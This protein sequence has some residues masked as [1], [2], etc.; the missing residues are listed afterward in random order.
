MHRKFSIRI[1][2]SCSLVSNHS[3]SHQQLT[4]SPEY[5]LRRAEIPIKTFSIHHFY[6]RCACNSSPIRV[7]YVTVLGRLVTV[8]GRLVTVAIHITDH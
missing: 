4:L 7:A 2:T 5:D 6:I 3:I 1:S 8:L